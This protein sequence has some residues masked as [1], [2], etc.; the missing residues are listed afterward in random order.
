M[1]NI[2]YRGVSGSHLANQH[3]ILS[4][5]SAPCNRSSDLYIWYTGPVIWY[6]L[7]HCKLYLD[8]YYIYIYILHKVMNNSFDLKDTCGYFIFLVFFKNL[9]LWT[10]FFYLKNTYDYFNFPVFKNFRSYKNS[11]N[12][13]F[14]PL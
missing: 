8:L 5:L 12:A 10:I 9:K 7:A 11:Y 1:L 13:Y 4:G 3:I 14:S 6:T 2:F